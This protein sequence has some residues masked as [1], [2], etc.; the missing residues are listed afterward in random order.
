MRYVNPAEFDPTAYLARL[1]ELVAHLPHGAA[2]FAA[3]PDHYDFFG[4]RCTKDLTISEW[5][6]DEAQA[7]AGIRFAGNP[8]KHDEDLIVEYVGVTDVTLVLSGDGP[9]TPDG[10]G[11][12]KLDEILPIDG[13]CSHEIAGHRGTLRITC[14]DLDASWHRV[15]RPDDPPPGSWTPE[16]PLG[17]RW[18]WLGRR[19]DGTWVVG[20]PHR[21]A[22]PAEESMDR[23]LTVLEQ[24]RSTV[25]ERWR[26]LPASAPALDD[27]LRHALTSGDWRGRIAL[28]WLEDGYPI[29]N[30]ISAL[31]VIKD[32]RRFSQQQRHRALRL[33][34]ANRDKYPSA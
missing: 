31:T 17:D 32:D 1:P 6:H 3:D 33:W 13:G 4:L 24:P 18:N 34:R 5:R 28:D 21:R 16:M 9:R 19:P 12:I 26:A 14:R 2:R 15:R 22:D 8:W 20:V 29:A 11:I 30:V 27:I 10:I 7:V 25:N 23:L